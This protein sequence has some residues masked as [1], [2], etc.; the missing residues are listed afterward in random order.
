MWIDIPKPY[1][2]HAWERC[3]VPAFSRGQIRDVN[4]GI[5]ELPVEM[6]NS[7]AIIRGLNVGEH[8]ELIC[9]EGGEG[10]EVNLEGMGAEGI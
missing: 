8:F 2:E 10:N 1:A 6:E 7:M 9:L 3:Q 5:S 4:R